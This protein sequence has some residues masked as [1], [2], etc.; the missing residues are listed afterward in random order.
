M[1]KNILDIETAIFNIKQ[2]KIKKDNK[3]YLIETVIL[4]NLSL[5]LE[6]YKN[7]I[8]ISDYDYITNTDTKLLDSDFVFKGKHL[9]NLLS[10]SY[11]IDTCYYNVLFHYFYNNIPLDNLLILKHTVYSSNSKPYHL[12]VRIL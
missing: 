3:K 8:N 11:E 1:I 9:H 2:S 7:L 12:V 5:L 6:K 10:T 4:N